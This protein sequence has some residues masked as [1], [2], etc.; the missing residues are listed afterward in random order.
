MTCESRPRGP[1]GCGPRGGHAVGSAPAPP[2]GSHAGAAA[3]SGSSSVV[4]QRRGGCGASAAARVAG[5][6]SCPRRRP[7]REAAAFMAVT[8]LLVL[9]GRRGTGD[10]SARF[11]AGGASDEGPRRAG[12]G[13][14]RA[15]QG[16][17][18]PSAA[19]TA[20]PTLAPF[21]SDL[22][23]V[24]L[25]ED[26]ETG[27]LRCGPLGPVQ[28]ALAADLNTVQAVGPLVQSAQVSSRQP[29][30]LHFHILVPRSDMVEVSEA[31]WRA[32]AFHRLLDPLAQPVRTSSSGQAV[33]WRLSSGGTVVRVLPFD[34]GHLER[35]I[36]VVGAAGIAVTGASTT[37]AR[38]DGA[39][40]SKTANDTAICQGLEGC[41]LSRAKRL[42]KA[43]NFARFF[44][45]PLLPE[46]A[47]VI[48]VD[49]DVLVRKDLQD[50]WSAAMPPGEATP[51]EVF[52]A[53][54]EEEAP[55]GRFYFGGGA[56][57]QALWQQ[58]RGDK[59]DLHATS[60]ND[61]VIVVDLEKWRRLKVTEEVEWWM[62]QHKAADP[63]LWKFGTQPIMLLLGA[64]GRW[65][66]LPG[67]WYMGDLGFRRAEGAADEAR[68][69]RATV[70]HFDGEHKPWLPATVSD[71]NAQ[72]HSLLASW[73]G[74][75][76]RPYAPADAPS[77]WL[78]APGAR[79]L[80]NVAPSSPC[81]VGPLTPGVSVPG[82]RWWPRAGTAA[83]VTAS[84]SPVATSATEALR[85]SSTTAA[86]SATAATA[87]VGARGTPI[88]PD[89][90]PAASHATLPTVDQFVEGFFSAAHVLKPAESVLEASLFGGGAVV[91]EALFLRPQVLTGAYLQ[92]FSPQHPVR[93]ARLQYRRG[94]RRGV[95]G[96][97]G[98]AAPWQDAC[99][100]L[101]P[102]ACEA[103]RGPSFAAGTS[104]ACWQISG[105]QG[106]PAARR[107]RV[108][109][110]HVDA[111]EQLLGGIWFQVAPRPAQ[112]PP[113]KAATARDSDQA[114]VAAA[115]VAA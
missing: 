43:T 104:F 13:P 90:F 64:G 100:L 89:L 33:R 31:L 2:A 84:S 91:L 42:S 17:A 5:A 113:M 93:G 72:R 27:P 26:E 22:A 115:I 37:D 20:A 87:G 14:Q 108:V 7:W 98:T 77:V 11:R 47:R 85:A 56:A 28:V 6:A 52:L 50:L 114:P 9:V 3:S 53:A 103:A 94:R 34:G 74:H 58:R 46:L 41:D 82:L 73:N 57:V 15:L 102:V 106:A 105:C 55:L 1:F 65:Q 99:G 78:A 109:G 10:T 18:A 69:A 38:A 68:L 61:G 79:C 81:H 29:K 110:W 71:E 80:W 88:E 44:L 45:A 66:R 101:R 12:P 70:L 51:P 23:A 32:L 63:A 112:W 36:K 76:L 62:Q 30:C 86:T 40:S 21:Q 83:T 16:E 92:A 60:F 111:A 49:C 25:P 39:G 8:A 19:A 75:L 67:E 4:T 107:W 59:L 54:F 24:P 35:H 95:R 48:W 97:V 96:A